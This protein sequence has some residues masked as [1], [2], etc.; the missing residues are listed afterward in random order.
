MIL[1]LV[2][3]IGRS[4]ADGTT[5][6]YRRTRGIGWWQYSLVFVVLL[7]RLLLSVWTGMQV[8]EIFAR[9]HYWLPSWR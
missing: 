1:G 4:S 8:P 5:L 2:F 9:L 3:V 7:Q 6:P